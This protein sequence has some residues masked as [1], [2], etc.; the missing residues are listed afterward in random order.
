[1]FLE[2]INIENT[3]VKRYR[4]HLGGQDMPSEGKQKEFKPSG[5]SKPK[6]G[7]GGAQR[8]Q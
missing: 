1:M 5:E 8:I 7:G 4:K 2:Y 3:V 6:G